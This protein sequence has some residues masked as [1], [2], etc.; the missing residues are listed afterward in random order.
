M[1]IPIH[2]DIVPLIKKRL[3]YPHSKVLIPNKKNMRTAYSSFR[4]RQWNVYMEKL[5]MNYTPHVMRHTFVSRMDKL[6]I[7]PITIRRI[8][9]HAN[10]NVT[11]VYTHKTIEDLIEAIDELKY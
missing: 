2:K 11:D 6:G 10:K 9:G 8:V 7:N 1:I 5:G 3:D 4:R